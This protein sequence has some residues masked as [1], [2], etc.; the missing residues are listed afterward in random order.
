MHA[1]SRSTTLKRAVSDSGLSERSGNVPV[2]Y[3]VPDKDPYISSGGQVT[4]IK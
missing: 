4:F 1:L 3:P 2:L